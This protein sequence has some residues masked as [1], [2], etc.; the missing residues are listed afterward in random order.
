MQNCASFLTAPC[1]LKAHYLLDFRMKITKV[2][3]LEGA[4]LALVGLSLFLLSY[5]SFMCM[6]NT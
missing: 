2:C 4:H 1:W 6:T 3:F 5:S